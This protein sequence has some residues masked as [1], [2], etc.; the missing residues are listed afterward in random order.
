MPAVRVLVVDDFVSFRRLVCSILEEEKGLLVVGEA[1]DGLEALQKVEALKPDLILLDMGLPHLN[2]IETARQ[3][4]DIAPDCKIIFLTLE[5]NP[6]VAQAALASG[7]LGYVVKVDIAAELMFAVRTVIRGE[8]FV[9]SSLLG[10]DL[11]EP[12]GN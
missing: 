12:P 3:I 7:A 8:R 2:G 1:S 4:R 11:N 5:R 9:S 6:E 10:Y